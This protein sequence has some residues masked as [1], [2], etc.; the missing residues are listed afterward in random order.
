MDK[1][2]LSDAI[3]MYLLASR[4]YILVH[5][6]IRGCIVQNKGVLS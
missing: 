6:S 5:S 1:D 3:R 4:V 2:V